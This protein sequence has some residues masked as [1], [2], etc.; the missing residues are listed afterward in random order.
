MYGITLRALQSHARDDVTKAAKREAICLA[1]RSGK[2]PA[3]IARWFKCTRSNVHMK[4]KD[5]TQ[6]NTVP[7]QFIT[8]QAR[9]RGITLSQMVGPSRDARAA[10]ARQDAMLAAYEAGYS[11]SSIGRA[12]NR[13]HTTVLHGIRRA[14]ERAANG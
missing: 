4:L 7:V 13:H 14:R 5:V 10:H 3:E 12:F 9:N 6:L 1:H 11:M 2:T 8:A